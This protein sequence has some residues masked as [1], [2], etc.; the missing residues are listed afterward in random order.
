MSS[1]WPCDSRS[2]VVPLIS[3]GCRRNLFKT[4]T[5]LSPHDQKMYI[6]V[7]GVEFTPFGVW[8][9]AVFGANIPGQYLPPCA[10]TAKI[11]ARVWPAADLPS[12]ALERW[13]FL[14]QPPHAFADPIRKGDPGTCPNEAGSTWKTSGVISPTF[15]ASTAARR[16]AS[17]SSACSNRKKMV[18]MG[19]LSPKP[20]QSVGIEHRVDGDQ[21]QLLDQGRDGDQASNAVRAEEDN[22]GSLP[23]NQSTAQVSRS[24]LIPCTPAIP[25]GGP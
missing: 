25:R 10:N 4:L 15:V 22:L 12:F 6:F 7:I 21:R 9:P 14:E 5:I 16:A 13:E 2:V 19:A 11:L 20:R 23:K 8:S 3:N 18:V 1:Q 17:L 24:S